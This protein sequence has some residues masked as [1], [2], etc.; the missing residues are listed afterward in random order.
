[1]FRAEVA[2]R[3]PEGHII[4][5]SSTGLPVAA[6]EYAIVGDMNNKYQLGLSTTLRYKGWTLSADFDI[7]KGG[8]MYSRTKDINYF[9]GNAI[10]TAYNDRNTFIVPNSVNR[11]TD[12]TGNVTYVENTTPITGSNIYAYWGAGGDG[13]GSASLI[14]KSFVKLRSL[15]LGWDVPKKWLAKT[16]I[17]ELRLSAYG[18]N[19]FLWT[20]SDNT[21]I[22]PE[23]TSFGNDLAGNFGEYTANPSSRRFGFNLMVK[24]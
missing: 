11:V 16:P 2:A 9:T 22:D 13:M 14:D 18:N 24:F 17:T 3:D 12:S 4:V 8:I 21:F 23:T 10:Q 7:R 20:P 1:M 6:D 5:N 15:V 19:L